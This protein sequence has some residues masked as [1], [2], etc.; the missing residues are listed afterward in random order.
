MDPAAVSIATRLPDQYPVLPGP[1]ID[2]AADLDG[3]SRYVQAP[4]GA[5]YVPAKAVRVP[6]VVRRALYTIIYI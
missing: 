1:A 6:A 2:S 5:I 4:N 3:V